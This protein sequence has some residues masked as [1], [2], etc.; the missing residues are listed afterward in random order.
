MNRAADS[1]RASAAPSGAGLHDAT[2][3]PRD[4]PLTLR[5]TLLLAA[6][7]ALAAALRLWGLDQNGWGAEYYTAAVRSMSEGWHNF[8]YAAFDP[9]GFISVDKPPVALWLQVLAVKLLG[10]SPLAVLLPQV[11]EGVL[12]VAL[13]FVLVRGAFGTAAAGW[14]ALFL[15]ITPISVAVNRTNNIDTCLV[16]VLLLAAWTLWQALR[17][18]QRGWL[19]GT[20]ALLG[21]AFNV[22]MLAA[23]IVVPALLAV[24]LVAAPHPMGR[25]LVDLAL[26]GLVLLATAA[27]WVLLYEL[28]PP[29][30]RPYAGSSRSNSMLEMVIGHNAMSRFALSRVPRA[31]RPA[32]EDAGAASGTTDGAAATAGRPDATD[33]AE[34]AAARAQVDLTTVDPR[35]AARLLFSRVL[36]RTPAGPFRLMGGQL[37]A[38]VV[39]MLPLALA[40]AVLAVLGVRRVRSDAAALQGLLWTLWAACCI[41]V[42]SALGG[43][44][45]FYYLSML[46]PALAALAGVGLVA[47]WRAWRHGGARAWLLPAALLATAGWQWHLQRGAVGWSLER[48]QAHAGDWQGWLA[49]VA[50]ALVA[51]SVVGLVLSRSRTVPGSAFLAV[52]IA[53]LSAIPL[54]WVASVVLLPGHGLLPSAD[55]ARLIATGPGRLSIARDRLLAQSPDVTRLT[56]LL[57]A[58][59]GNERFL[60]TTSTTQYAA[61][62]I[63]R[64]G[65]PVLARGGF[66]GLDAAMT[67]AR[68]ER[69]VDSGELRFALVGDLTA[70]SRRLGSEVASRPLTEWIRANGRRVD[71]A[72]WKPAR[73]AIDAELYELAP[74]GVAPVARAEVR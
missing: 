28:T 73:G 25:S 63:I 2:T 35:T 61:P 29:E 67:R 37:G 24:W 72:L 49:M 51:A 45:H 17:S 18:G 66:G 64:T 26:A 32:P 4:V 13:L 42:F 74:V 41:G 33:P 70:V 30:A 16:F 71:P 52:G 39:W 62:I 47:L 40:G 65:L 38:Q 8:L 69:L 6:L 5:D 9:T 14:S 11:I 23:F 12:S 1:D 53:G 7:L 68:L 19:L 54:A 50:A 55:L 59:R 3:T 56:D 43:I 15:A 27:P 44:I 60:L 34:A 21:I 20:A 58:Q 46:A 48:L 31:V 10:F 22:K 36:V 57:L